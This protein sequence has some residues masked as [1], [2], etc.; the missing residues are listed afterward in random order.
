MPN[1]LSSRSSVAKLIFISLGL[2]MRINSA[3]SGWVIGRTRMPCRPLETALSTVGRLV[4]SASDS[5]TE[6]T[7][8]PDPWACDRAFPYGIVDVMLRDS[9][10]ADEPGARRIAGAFYPDLASVE[11]IPSDDADVFRLTFTSRREPRIL[12]MATRGIR[13]VWREIGAF[14]AMRRLGVPEVLQFE[15]MTDDLPGIGLEFHVTRAL[16]DPKMAN[17]ALA[18][19]WANDRR[20]D[21]ARPGW[22]ICAHRLARSRGSS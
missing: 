10:T 22:R 14:P 19:L 20:R 6:V 21:V 5:L 4:H 11:W 8:S 2:S 1:F 17:R 18:D 15:Y 9:R 13:A 16:G 7:H 12:K 3:W